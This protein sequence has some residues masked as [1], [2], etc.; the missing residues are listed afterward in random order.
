MSLDDSYEFETNP[1]H[2][3]H[4][5][6]DSWKTQKDEAYLEYRR[7]WEEV[8]ANKVFLDFPIHLDIE[9]TTKCNLKCPMCSRTLQIENG[10]F[11][12][13]GFISKEEYANIIDQ[14]VAMGTKSIKLNYLGE[15]LLHKDVVW[16]VA[17]AKEKGII[18][19]MMNSNASALT[20]KNS[21]ALLEA[22]LD[23]MFISMDAVNPKDFETQRIGTTIG[24]VIDNTYSFIKLREKIR[25]ACQVRLSMI[26]YD[27]PKWAAQH[28]AMKVMW[29]GLV[30]AVNVNHYC[31]RSLTINNE[32]PEIKGFHCSQPFH[33]MFLKYSGKVTVCCF[34]DR[35]ETPMGDWRK[36]S[37]HEIWNSAPYNHFR[38][39]HAENKY[40]KIEM[41]RQC[42]IPQCSNN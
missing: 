12:E 23:N 8:P 42:T 14:A 40:Y 9:T 5:L 15:P 4:I 21:Q 10:D 37:L 2:I 27:D 38:T 25:P 34:D 28:E 35:D 19:V 22:G 32:F 20:E 36:Q 33:R 6:D 13:N 7:M 1:N 41:C 18:D 30:D 17:Y 26:L 3:E 29:E 39:M 11:E 24:R 16:Q 31:D